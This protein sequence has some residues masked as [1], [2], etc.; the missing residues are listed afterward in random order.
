MTTDTAVR[1]T[2]II[3]QD[4][5]KV[6]DIPYIDHPDLKVD[7]HESVEMPFRYVRDKEGKPIMPE[8]SSILPLFSRI[9]WGEGE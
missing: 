2:R 9:F 7:E 4:K 5:V 1:V 3:V 8:V 6:E